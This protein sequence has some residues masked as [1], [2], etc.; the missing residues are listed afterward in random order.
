MDPEYLSDNVREEC[1]VAADTPKFEADDYEI[2]RL[3]LG[4]QVNC[5]CNADLKGEEKAVDEAE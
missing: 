4:C 5:E 2:C 1:E 3:V